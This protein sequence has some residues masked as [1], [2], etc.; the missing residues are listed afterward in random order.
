[1]NTVDRKIDAILKRKAALAAA[2]REQREKQK[3]TKEK[4]AVILAKIVGKA[5]LANPKAD[6]IIRATLR[7]ADLIDSE[8]R[9]LARKGF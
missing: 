3:A 9:F 5:L 8:K 2:L 7:T 4:D 1:M 6:E